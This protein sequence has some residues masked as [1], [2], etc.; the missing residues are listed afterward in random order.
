MITKVYYIN[1]DR[2][3]HF[4]LMKEDRS[5]IWDNNEGPF[6]DS[7]QAINFARRV[8]GA[9]VFCEPEEPRKKSSR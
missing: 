3:K 7:Q 9:E 1:E 2:E 4:L 8:R 6:S 5:F